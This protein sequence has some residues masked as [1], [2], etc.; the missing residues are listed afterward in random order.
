MVT[1]ILSL[2]FYILIVILRQFITVLLAKNNSVTSAVFDYSLLQRYINGNSY[3]TK[4][5]LS[6]L[7]VSSYFLVSL[8]EHILK[9]LKVP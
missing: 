2:I 8:R 6:P 1:V 5:V 7:F 9:E 4:L 3:G